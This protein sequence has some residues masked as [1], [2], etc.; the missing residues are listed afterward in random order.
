MAEKVLN[1]VGVGYK[2]CPEDIPGTTDINFYF[3]NVDKC[4]GIPGSLC[5]TEEDVGATFLSAIV[6]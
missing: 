5:C 4:E 1:A 3:Y 6:S 2:I